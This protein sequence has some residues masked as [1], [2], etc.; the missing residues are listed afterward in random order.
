MLPLRDTIPSKHFPKASL[1]IILINIFVFLFEISLPKEQLMHFLNLYGM[2]PSHLIAQPKFDSSLFFQFIPLISSQFLHGGWLHIIMNMWVLWIFTDN[3]EEVV[4]SGR[5][6]LF[7]LACGVVACLIQALVFPESNIPTIGA[8]GAI[9]GVMGA[10][11][12]LFP[13]SKIV[14]LIP[15]FFYPLLVQISAIFFLIYWFL[16]QLLSG[17]LSVSGESVGGVAWWAH[18]GGFVTGFLLSFL[19]KR[20][21]HPLDP[22]HRNFPY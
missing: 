15:I 10:Y 11:L 17:S 18:V 9:S 14:T 3:V 19:V 12:R 13:R 5:F 2:V 22:F 4:G 8:S 20:R 1:L 21:A 6:I 16:L 7:Y